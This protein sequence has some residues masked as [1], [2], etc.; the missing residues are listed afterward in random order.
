[1]AISNAKYLQL[2]STLIGRRQAHGDIMDEYS[3][4]SGQFSQQTCAP[5]ALLP[6]DRASCDDQLSA[7]AP[8]SFP[9]AS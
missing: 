4:K 9:K 5:A 6:R 3:R 2:F 1:M 7:A 8:P